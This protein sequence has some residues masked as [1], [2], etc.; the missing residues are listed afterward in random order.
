MPLYGFPGGY[1]MLQLDPPVTTT[2]I[3]DWRQNIL[4]WQAR[5]QDVAPTRTTGKLYWYGDAILMKR[6]GGS[7]KDYISWD[8]Q[9]NPVAPQWSFNKANGVNCDIVYE[10]C[11]CTIAN[12]NGST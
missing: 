11:S 5:F 9:T 10:F 8:N 12:S 4:D 6:I 1:G 7:P 2:G 3:W